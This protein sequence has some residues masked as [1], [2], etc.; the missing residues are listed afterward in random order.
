MVDSMPTFHG[1]LED[2]WHAL[3]QFL[4]TCSAWSG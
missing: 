4:A 3:A 1:R 2:Q